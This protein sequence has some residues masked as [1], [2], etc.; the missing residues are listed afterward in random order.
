MTARVYLADSFK[1][2]AATPNAMT[3]VV[4]TDPPYSPHVHANLCSGSLVGTKNVPKYELPFE[5]LK[6]GVEGYAFVHDLV[7]VARRWSIMFCDVEA[8]GLVKTIAPAAYVRGGVW[9]KSNAMGQLTG[10]RPATAYEGVTVLHG[11]KETHGKKRWN[12]RGSYGIWRCNGTRG[13]KGRHPNEKPLDLALKLVALFSERGETV[14]DPFCGAGTIGEACVRLGRNY[15]GIDNDPKWVA[16]ALE[17]VSHEYEPMTDEVALSLCSM[18]GEDPPMPSRSEALDE[19]TSLSEEMGLYDI[20][21]P[22]EV[23]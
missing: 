21:P 16:T 18:R 5:A 22:P 19:L 4:I 23:A 10:D 2:L 14:F 9:Y 13:K 17:R 20:P 1:I 8:F 12:G 3:D 6:A 15:I 11:P 7:R